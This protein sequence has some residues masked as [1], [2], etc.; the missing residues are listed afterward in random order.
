MIA[1]GEG[2][3]VAVAQAEHPAVILVEFATLDFHEAEV[4]HAIVCEAM[5]LSA[6][7]KAVATEGAFHL[8]YQFDVGNRAGDLHRRGWTNAEVFRTE[9]LRSRMK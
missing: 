6:D 2:L 7:D 8:L 1:G 4:A 5:S 3:V 9:C